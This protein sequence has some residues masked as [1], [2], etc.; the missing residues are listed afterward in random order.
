MSLPCQHDVE[1]TPGR[2][3]VGAVG[4]AGGGG[5]GVGLGLCA[6]AA[7]C[8]HQHRQ[9]Q[10]RCVRRAPPPDVQHGLHQQ[11]RRA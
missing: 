7:I 1:V 10:Q 3:A 2:A 9:G 5:H 11:Q 6:L 4:E 8:L